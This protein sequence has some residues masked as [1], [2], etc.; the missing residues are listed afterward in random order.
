MEWSDMVELAF[1]AAFS[2]AL[3][4]WG[5]FLLKGDERSFRI[6]AGGRDFLALDPDERAYRRTARESGVAVFLVAV[7]I[8]CF[9]VGDVASRIDV[10]APF[11]AEVKMACAVIG[12]VSTA[13]LAAIVVAQVVRHGRFAEPEIDRR[14]CSTARRRLREIRRFAAWLQIRSLA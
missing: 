12:A 10:L 6:L 5:A 2:A 8:L 14:G 11:A 4:V 9:I 7:M 3:F 13:I 1:G